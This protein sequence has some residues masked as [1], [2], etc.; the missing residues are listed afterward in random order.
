MQVIGIFVPTPTPQALA[1][2]EPGRV[3]AK[4]VEQAGAIAAQ[5]ALNNRTFSGNKVHADS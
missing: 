5:R 1:N 3:Y 2:N 4:F